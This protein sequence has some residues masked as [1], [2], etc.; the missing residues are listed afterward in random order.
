MLDWLIPV[1]TMHFL[2]SSVKIK[3]DLD[4]GWKG[5]SSRADTG[6]LRE[7]DILVNSQF[8]RNMMAIAKLSKAEFSCILTQSAVWAG[9]HAV[10]AGGTCSM[11]WGTCSIGRGTF[12][13]GW[14]TS[15]IVDKIHS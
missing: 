5:R 11:G 8:R 12:S 4:V 1:F 13:M 6:G 9:V 3:K 15:G 10:W 2:Y 14:G 7:T